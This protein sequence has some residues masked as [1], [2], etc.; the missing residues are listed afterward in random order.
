MRGKRR[1]VRG[2]AAVALLLPVVV[3]ALVLAFA[4]VALADQWTDITDATWVNT[5]K[6]TAAQAATVSDGYTDGTFRPKQAVTRGQFAKFTVDGF[7]VAT[8]NSATPTFSDVS[9]SSTFYIWIEGGYAAKILS[10]FT[11][12]TYRPNST[13]TRQQSNNILGAYLSSRE[14]SE[15]GKI[16]GSKG[17]YSSLSAWYAAEGPAILATFNDATSVAAVHAPG[18]AY[19]VYHQVVQGSNGNL[20][21]ASNLTRAQ[22]VALILRVKAVTFTGGG[23]GAMPVVSLV[24]PAAGAASG[25]N[26]VSISGANFTGATAVKFGTVAATTFTVNSATSI[27]AVVPAGTAGTTVDVTVTTA[28]G[29]SAV[30]NSTK[31]SYGPPTVTKLEPNGG[32]TAGGTA[33]TITGTGFTGV[34]YVRF[35]STVATSFVVLNPNTITAVSPP[36]TLGTSVDVVVTTPAGSS[37]TSTATKFTYGIPTVTK[38]VPAAGPAAGGTTVVI[39]GT[40]FSQISGAAGVKFGAVNATSYTV[41]S[42]NQITAVAPAGT[43]GTTVD[44]VVT[45]AVGASGTSYASKYSY[46]APTITK[47]NPTGGTQAGGTMVLITG[48]GFTGVSSVKFGNTAAKTFIVDSPTQITA[49]TPAGTAGATVEVTVTTPAGTNATTGSANDFYYGVPTVTLVNPAAGPAAGGNSVVITGTNFVNVTKVLFGNR[50][51]TSYTVNSA[52]QITAVAPYGTTGSTVD[53]TVTT[54]AGV[55]DVTLAAK[56]SYGAP[57]VTTV[58]PTAGSPGGGNTV[59]ITGEGF[60]GVTSVKFGSIDASFTVVSATSITATAPAGAL[61]STVNVTVTNPAGTSS[62][63]TGTKYSYIAGPTVSSISPESGV[64]GTAVTITGTYFTSDSTVKFGT[65]SATITSINE[66][67]TQIVATAPSGVT[68]GS[69]VDVRVTNPVGTSPNTANDNFTYGMPIVE[70]LNPSAGPNLGGNTVIIT[71]SAFVNVTK[72][73]FYDDN[74]TPADLTDD[75]EYP[76]SIVGSYTST[77]ITVT[78]PNGPN[79]TTVDVRVTNAVG[80]SASSGASKYAFGKP[81]LDHIT[82]TGGSANTLVTIYGTGFTGTTGSMTVTFTDGTNSAAATITDIDDEDFSYIVV[83]APAAGSMVSPVDIVVTNAF[84]SGTLPNAFYYGV[85]TVTSVSPLAGPVNGGNSVVITGTGFLSVPATNG[86]NFYYAATSTDYLSP[87]YSIDSD[88]QITAEA[89]DGPNN[90]IVDIIVSNTSGGSSATS[91]KTKYNFGPG[92]VTALSPSGGPTV[93]GTEVTITGT[94]FIGVTDVMFGAFPAEDYEVIDYNTIIAVS[95]D[96]ETAVDV[97]VAVTNPAGTGATKTYTYGLPVIASLS[98]KA[99]PVAGNNTVTITGTGFGASPTV[100]FGGTPATIVSSTTTLITVKAPPGTAGATVYVHVDNGPDTSSETDECLYSYGPPEVTLLTENGGKTIGGETV[101]ITGKGFTGVSAVKFG[102]TALATS[103]YTVD[104]PTQ[105]TATAPPGTGTVHVTV[106]NPAGTSATTDVYQSPTKYS[107]GLPTVTGL[108]PASGIPGT[109]VIITGTNLFGVEL[110]EFGAGTPSTFVVINSDT[111]ITVQAPLGGTGTKGVQVTNGYGTSTVTN[112]NQYY[113]FDL[114]TVTNLAPAYGK[115]AGG[116]TVVIT[117]T[118]FTGVTAVKFG[119]TTLAPSDYTV[120]SR[121]QI[122]AEAPPA[123]GGTAGQTVTVAVVNGVGE[124]VVTQEYAYGIPTVTEVDPAAGALDGSGGPVVITGTN[125]VNVPAVNGVDFY[126]TAAATH[127]YAVTYTIDSATQIT[128]TGLPDGP[129]YITVDVRVANGTGYWSVISSK[130]WYSFGAPV[131]ENLN[132]KKGSRGTEVYITGKCFTGV[133][134]VT[135]GGE[136]ADF[137]VESYGAIRCEVPNGL[138]VGATVQVRVTN[139][140]GQSA[141]NGTIDDFLVE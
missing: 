12:G 136:S 71:G 63:G 21:P 34:T 80:T 139:S 84:G 24:N 48:T 115:V 37:A 46:G 110:V 35:G 90:M 94:G 79:D 30:S 124:S 91:T 28:G 95:P 114:P 78:A 4:G 2:R 51:A 130:D 64:A 20:T 101:V 122:T 55:S 27:M 120:D 86:V 11:D 112:N 109:G 69:T 100:D 93:G 73:V 119:L 13:I 127:Y 47:L 43:E 137:D 22:A 17:T 138:T 40:G 15:K 99:G 39:T 44:V 31:Y 140:A 113:T 42:V 129:D 8:K 131:I 52:T 134:S 92:R 105:I 23:T 67:G 7:G 111:Q 14:L 50:A 25:G 18:T 133:T 72:V 118:G 88:T 83:K 61:D 49:T 62:T 89:P 97:Q 54:T 9:K 6:V 32:S 75:T 36:G 76:A 85:P 29:T 81:V 132:P 41:D 56:Y 96:H 57:K 65:V 117:G 103:A 59:T 121:T 98:P 125:F 87:S 128:V 26:A 53:V 10:G 3:V 33:V 135:F 68:S 70:G 116:D 1:G 5:Y 123:P 77:Q 74:G 104:S 107:Y 66:A 141:N 58:S 19:L 108:A 16:T 126:D 102:T 60:T 106:T 45:N 82:P 38:L